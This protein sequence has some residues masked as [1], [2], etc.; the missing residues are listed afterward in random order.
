MYKLFAALALVLVFALA[1]SLNACSPASESERQ[2]HGAFR[3]MCNHETLSYSLTTA[4]N[5]KKVFTAECDA[6]AP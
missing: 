1:L 6:I 3:S 4:D 2:A 5:G